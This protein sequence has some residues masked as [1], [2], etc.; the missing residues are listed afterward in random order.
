MGSVMGHIHKDIYKAIRH[1]LT[2]R[3]M[4]VRTATAKVTKF[5]FIFIF[6][7]NSHNILLCLVFV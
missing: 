3:V 4:A 5:N 7:I 2:D 1:S 6:V